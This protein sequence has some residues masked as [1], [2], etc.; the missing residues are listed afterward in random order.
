M[1]ALRLP[2]L[3]RPLPKTQN[4]EPQS[5][6][7]E[8]AFSYLLFLLL[9]ESGGSPPPDIWGR[10]IVGRKVW[11]CR[12]SAQYARWKTFWLHSKGTWQR[13]TFIEACT[14]VNVASCPTSEHV[15]IRVSIRVQTLYR[16]SVRIG[17]DRPRL[18]IIALSVTTTL[19]RT[20]EIRHNVLNDPAARLRVVRQAPVYFPRT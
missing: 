11:V 13:Q 10:G 2:E 8:I 7:W 9:C 6:V 19:C 5:T 18:P 17:S 4:K 15:A 20:F 14:C 1:Q 3:S 12:C 16:R